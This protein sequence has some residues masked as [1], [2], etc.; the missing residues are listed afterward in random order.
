MQRTKKDMTTEIFSKLLKHI[1]YYYQRGKQ[2]EISMTGVGEG[3]M[4][5]EIIN[6][7][8]ILRYNFPGMDI[9]LSTNG[10]LLTEEMAKCFSEVGLKLMISLH[11][12]EI[13]G[14]AIEIARKFDILKYVNDQFV[15]SSTNWA[16]T[17]EWPATMERSECQYLNQ[18]W[19]AVLADGSINTC[20]WDAEGQGIIGHVRE[21]PGTHRVKPISLCKDC[22]LD[23]PRKF[24]REVV[25][26]EQ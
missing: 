8:Y 25:T 24:N 9:Y 20:C 21:E 5:P 4:H 10:L 14:K 11:R 18:G 23:V 15:T 6:M 1:E 7:A 2:T 22:S 26:N 17:V 16:G 12:P 19:G 3:L 13:A